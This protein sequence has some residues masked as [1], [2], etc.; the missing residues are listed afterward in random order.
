MKW[1]L[2]KV[3]YTCNTNYDEHPRALALLNRPKFYWVCSVIDTRIFFSIE[4][5]LLQYYYKPQVNKVCLVHRKRIVLCPSV[6]K[7]N[8]VHRKCIV[9]LSVHQSANIICTI[10]FQKLRIFLIISMIIISYIKMY[11]CYFHNDWFMVH[12]FFQINGLTSSH[13]SKIFCS[14][15]TWI[16]N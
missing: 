14:N 2:A 12:N 11:R 7:H 15:I 6:C 13:F 3:P 9:Q 4:S 5:T 16:W 10:Q 1:A 8:L